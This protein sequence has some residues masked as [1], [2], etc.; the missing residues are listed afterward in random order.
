MDQLQKYEVYPELAFVPNEEPLK[1]LPDQFDAWEETIENLVKLIKE[2]DLQENVK[3][4]PLLVLSDANLPTVRHWQRAYVVLTFVGQGYIWMNGPDNP[5]KEIPSVLAK[6][7]F[8]AAEHLGLPP[9]ITYAAVVLYNWELIDP[10][11]CV[12][13]R[14]VRIRY[15]FTGTRDESEFYRV[16]LLCEFA[17]AD[18]VLAATKLISEDQVD[19]NVFSKIP[20]AIKNIEQAML[21]MHDNITPRVFYKDIRPFFNGWKNVRFNGITQEQ[22]ALSYDGAS[23]AESSLIP[24]FDILLAIQHAKKEFFDKQRDYMPKVHRDFLIDL[25]D[26]AKKSSLPKKIAT[27]R[28]LVKI[29]NRCVE[30][31][32]KFRKEHR[33]LVEVMIVKFNPQRATGTGGLSDLESVLSDFEQD[34]E[35]STL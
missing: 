11:K 15:T 18:G 34:T 21:T 23:A 5:A 17:G 14:N 1:R 3:S 10:R 4:W 2:K 32:V 35:R 20:S 16:S 27:N 8:D 19:E 31:L 12:E 24:V 33:K 9:V 22:N 13:P 30:N 7:W 6:P 29:Y 25:E 28:E 26:L